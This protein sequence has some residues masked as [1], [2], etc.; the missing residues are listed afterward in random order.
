MSLERPKAGE[1][2]LEVRQADSG[3]EAWNASAPAW[4]DWV[5]QDGDPGR[6]HVLDGPM[7]AL[8]Q[9][10]GAKT[11]LD[12]GCGEGRF[13]R[14]L[15]AMG[16]RPTGLEPVPALLEHARSVQP[17]AA[18]IE[19]V[20]EA[21]PFPDE[22]F[23]LVVSYVSMVDIPDHRAAISEIARVLKPG[24]TF[25]MANL[26][27]HVT[28]IS[29]DAREDDDRWKVGDDGKSEFTM[30]NYLKEFDYFIRWGEIRLRCYHR[31]LSSYMTAALDA[32]LN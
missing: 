15:G 32:E 14:M 3:A 5:N 20:A 28:A 7:I 12:V 24:G 19:G 17:D 11:A 23:P 10:T 4:I 27:P 26:C 29:S 25:L 16:I 31:P 18:F 8:A 1:S 21:M 6:I 2:I 9:A 13:S 30:D 22:T